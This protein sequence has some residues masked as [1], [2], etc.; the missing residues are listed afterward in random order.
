MEFTLNFL[1]YDRF[2]FTNSSQ[3]QLFATIGL[4]AAFVQ[5]FY[6]RRFAHKH[7]TEKTLVVQGMTSCSIAFLI[8]GIWATSVPFL[9]LGAIF[10]AFTNGTG[11]LI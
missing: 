5:G 2:A 7:V 11:M 3:G 9:Y 10:L 4:T 1:S 6:I 8:L